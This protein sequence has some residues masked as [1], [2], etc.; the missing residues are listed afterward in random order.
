M[1]VCLDVLEN[2]S[3]FISTCMQLMEVC[4]LLQLVATI[5]DDPYLL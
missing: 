5:T 2:I 4:I 3:Y 1:P